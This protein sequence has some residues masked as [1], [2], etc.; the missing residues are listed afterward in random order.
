MFRKSAY[1]DDPET[2]KYGL[3]MHS[4]P[5]FYAGP[6]KTDLHVSWDRRLA[7]ARNP[8]W[9]AYLLKKAELAVDAGASVPHSGDGDDCDVRGF[10]H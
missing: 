2:K 8:G 1:R 4:V 7:D 9:R 3:W 10:A 6:T 5:M